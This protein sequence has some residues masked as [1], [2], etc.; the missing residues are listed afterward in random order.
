MTKATPRVSLLCLLGS[1]LSTPGGGFTAESNFSCNG[2]R[3]GSTHD[4]SM[5]NEKLSRFRMD[6]VRNIDFPEALIFYDNPDK[7]ILFEEDGK[8]VRCGLTSLIDECRDVATPAILI[9][10][11]KEKQKVPKELKGYMTVFDELEMPPNPRSLYSAIESITIQPQG[12]GGSSG[13]GRKQ[14]DPERPPMPHHTVVFCED[15][16]VTRAARYCGMRVLSFEDNDLAD[17]IVDEYD[18]Y[19]EDIAT[20]GSFW[21]NPPY[22]RDDDGNKVD[23]FDMMERMERGPEQDESSSEINEDERLAA[24]LKDLDPL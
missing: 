13:F 8:T 4:E 12:F 22:S 15:I 7:S 17:A 11:D 3:T 23:V 2:P 18:F 19:L 1:L 16:G 20:P 9:S 5:R 6:M 14:A 10:K 21:L 24:I